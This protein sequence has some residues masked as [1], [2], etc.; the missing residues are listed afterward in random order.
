M[1]DKIRQIRF[2]ELQ[3]AILADPAKVSDEH[4]IEFIHIGDGRY[5]PHM[6][7]LPEDEQPKESEA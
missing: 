1:T 6:R 7:A 2:D 3:E 4:L 5:F